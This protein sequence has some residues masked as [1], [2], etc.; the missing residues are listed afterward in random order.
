M[1]E[2]Q[3]QRERDLEEAAFVLNRLEVKKKRRGKV[4]MQIQEKISSPLSRC[5]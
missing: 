1:H 3:I 2:V 4:K 5:K